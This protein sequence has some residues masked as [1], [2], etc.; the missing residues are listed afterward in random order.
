M[1]LFCSIVQ[2]RASDKR[3]VEDNSDIIFFLFLNE[4]ML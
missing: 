3:G 4:N 1:G 2:F